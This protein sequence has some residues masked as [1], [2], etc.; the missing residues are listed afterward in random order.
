[1]AP[2]R[3]FVK[4]ANPYS[5]ELIHRPIN[6]VNYELL[7]FV[8]FYDFTRIGYAARRTTFYA[9]GTS[10]SV[11]DWSLPIDITTAR[12][13]KDLAFGFGFPKER[14]NWTDD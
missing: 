10:C 5:H 7:R 1:M 6:L 8:T 4:A 2:R 11:V 14:K 3:A 12:Q 9:S 13:P